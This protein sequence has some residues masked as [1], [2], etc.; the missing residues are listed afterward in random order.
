MNTYIWRVGTTY[1]PVLDVSASAEW[2]VNHLGAKLTYQDEDKAIINLANQSFFLVKSKEGETLD[3]LDEKGNVR[4]PLTFEVDGLE[5]LEALH[6]DLADKKVRVGEIENRGH[7]GRNFVFQDPNGNLFDVWS[8]LSPVF[9][10][11]FFDFS[12]KRFV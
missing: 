8:E 2:Y 6:K 12:V 4:F 7:A 5:A 3:F 10:E 9:R 11:K 1:L